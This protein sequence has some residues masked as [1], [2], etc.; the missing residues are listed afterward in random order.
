VKYWKDILEGVCSHNTG[1]SDAQRKKFKKLIQKVNSKFLGQDAIKEQ[2]D[3]MEFGNLK[4]DGHDHTSVAERLFEIKEDLEL[5][6]KEVGKFSI[7]EMAQRIIPNT[8]KTAASLRFY[9]KGGEDL[10][11]SKEIIELCRKITTFLKRE[12]NANRENTDNRNSRGSRSNRP[13]SNNGN[14]N[15]NSAPCRK[16]EGAHLWKDCPENWQ[17]KNRGNDNAG[18][19]D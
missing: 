11:D 3:V 19:S 8:L 4:Y 2:R 10:R 15:G 9:D 7:Q 1:D 5:F 18:T 13:T 6:G 17:N 12:A 14:G 16:H